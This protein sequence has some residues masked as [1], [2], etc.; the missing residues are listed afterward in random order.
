MSDVDNWKC[1]TYA[2]WDCT[3]TIQRLPVLVLR[4][5]YSHLN[6]YQLTIQ[7]GVEPQDHRYAQQQ[8]CFYAMLR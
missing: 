3:S 5:Y 2:L 8:F 7:S 1:I 6:V 4:I